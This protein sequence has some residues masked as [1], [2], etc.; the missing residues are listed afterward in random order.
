[1]TFLQDLKSYLTNNG[2]NSIFREF[3]P[4]QPDDCIGL[5]CWEHTVGRINDGSGWRYLQVQARNRDPEAA[6]R[7]AHEIA[8]LLDS[9]ED[10]KIIHLTDTR[11]C[12]G[13]TRRLPVKLAADQTRTTY[14]FETALWGDNEE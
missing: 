13:R 5:F 1:M 6:Y 8:K 7:T 12:I 2:F 3:L 11:W 10:E 9:G 4:D 14:Y